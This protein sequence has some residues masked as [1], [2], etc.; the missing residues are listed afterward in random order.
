MTSFI[1][2]LLK[3]KQKKLF[4]SQ[5]KDEK[6]VGNS[7]GLNICFDDSMIKSQLKICIIL[8]CQQQYTITVDSQIIM[9]FFLTIF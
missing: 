6:E 8:F 7:S 9:L 3:T 1:D 5:N 2:I 4:V